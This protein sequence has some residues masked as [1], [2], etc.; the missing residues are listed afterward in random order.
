M[1]M[2]VFQGVFLTLTSP[3]STHALTLCPFFISQHWGGA[4]CSQMAA[5]N[6]RVFRLQ[7]GSVETYVWRHG[8]SVHNIYRQ[9]FW[10]YFYAIGAPFITLTVCSI[11]IFVQ[12]MPLLIPFRFD[13]LLLLQ[14]KKFLS[15]QVKYKLS[16]ISS[17]WLHNATVQQRALG[18]LHS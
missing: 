8:G 2:G 5:P 18:R 14:W 10:H 1:L 4:R 16:V 17:V 6:V 9:W 12:S 15:I 13:C 7:N 11:F 3:S